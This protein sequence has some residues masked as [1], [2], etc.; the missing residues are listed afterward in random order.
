MMITIANTA[1]WYLHALNATVNITDLPRWQQTTGILSRQVLPK[2]VVQMV[3]ALKRRFTLK[4][5]PLRL[6]RCFL[7]PEENVP[8]QFLGAHC[9]CNSSC[10][11]FQICG[12]T[13]KGGFSCTSFGLKDLATGVIF[14]DFLFFILLGKDVVF[15]YFFI[16]MLCLPFSLS[17]A[18]LLYHHLPLFWC[19][20][21]TI[22]D[23]LS[24][25]V[26]N[27][28]WGLEHVL[29]VK[30]INYIR[31]VYSSESVFYT[32]LLPGCSW[33]RLH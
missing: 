23:I 29:L 17:C 22:K 24:I 27:T 1:V 4:S 13:M 9:S 26:C 28:G 8:V 19:Y 14:P 6:D 3:P 33:E 32:V 7:T 31:G 10:K 11:W 21:W 15:Q 25:P 5:P 12:W 16:S 2:G 18:F 30:K 20:L